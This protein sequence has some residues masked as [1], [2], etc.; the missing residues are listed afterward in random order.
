MPTPP[1]LLPQLP[2]LKFEQGTYQITPASRNRRLRSGVYPAPTLTN[3][4][5]EPYNSVLTTHAMLEHSDRSFIVGNKAN[6]YICK[7]SL[8]I[9]SPSFNLIRLIA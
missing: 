4:I 2:T 8:N 6:Y 1:P 3:S 5:V 7:K 9:S